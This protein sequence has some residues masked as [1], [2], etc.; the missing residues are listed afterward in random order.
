MTSLKQCCEE[1]GLEPTVK[2]LDASLHWFHVDNVLTNCHCCTSNISILFA[3]HVGNNVSPLSETHIFET[4]CSSCSNITTDT[5]EAQFM[6]IHGTRSE[7]FPYIPPVKSCAECHRNIFL[8]TLDS[9]QTVKHNT[10][11]PIVTDPTVINPEQQVVP[12]LNLSSYF[13]QNFTLSV[14]PWQREY[15]WDATNEE[16]EVGVL[17]DDLKQFAEDKD[18]SEYLL[19]AV[20]LCKTDDPEVVY[21]IDGQQRTVTLTLLIMCCYQY[22]KENQLLSAEHFR[23]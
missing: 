6:T 1:Y 3:T 20:I 18:K 8:S 15:T 9:V 21:L 19:G 16:G 14:P 7:D 23:F 4:L 17:L 22:L 2:E 10:Q 5:W 13:T 11:M 12:V